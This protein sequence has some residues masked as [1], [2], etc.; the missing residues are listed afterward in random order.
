MMPKRL[1]SLFLSFTI[2]CL[3]F[4]SSIFAQTTC[5]LCGK[6][7]GIAPSDYDTCVACLYENPGTPPTN[8]KTD[9]SW[10]VIGCIPTTPAGFTQR[11][12]QL[13]VA[14]AGG[15]AFVTLLMGSFRVLTSSGDPARLNSGKGLIVS[16]IIAL[17]LVIF[18]V[19]ILRFV[20]VSILKIP[21]FGE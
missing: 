12:L 19:F 15:I 10:T 4:T 8:P 6:C 2:Y 11:I 1:L 16:S 7:N 5:D 3:L 18:A 20:G 21:G 13:S 9:V 14:I 17:L